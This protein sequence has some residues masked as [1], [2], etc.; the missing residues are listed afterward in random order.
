MKPS[1]YRQKLIKRLNKNDW[2]VEFYV[3]VKD[4]DHEND[5]VYRLRT[6]FSKGPIFFI[7]RYRNEITNE[8]KM[9]SV[10]TDHPNTETTSIEL[11]VDGN[12]RVKY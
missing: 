11:L 10:R 9:F 8:Y 3:E 4:Y 6:R 5:E 2:P 1:S 7:A 12:N